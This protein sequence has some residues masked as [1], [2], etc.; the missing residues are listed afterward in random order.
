MKTEVARIEPS[1]SP[2]RAQAFVHH[3]HKDCMVIDYSETVNRFTDVDAYQFP[4]MEVLADKATHY[5]YFSKIDLKAAYHQVPLKEG[6]RK[7]RAFEVNRSL[8][9]CPLA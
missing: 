2:W 3:G 7:Y 1:T 5:H 4:E 8:Q 9:N 6:E